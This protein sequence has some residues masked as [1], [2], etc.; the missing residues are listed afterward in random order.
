MIRRRGFRIFVLIFVIVALSIAT[1]SFKEVHISFLGANLDRSGDGP[2]G[3][4]LGLDL[5]GGIDLVYQA[6]LPDEVTVTFQDVVEEQDLRGVLDDLGHSQA[7]IGKK[8]YR[9]Q[10]LTTGDISRK[11]GQEDALRN[12]LEQLTP[13]AAFVTGDETLDVTFRLTPMESDIRIILDDLDY[14]EATILSG[15]QRSF[16]IQGVPL[17]DEVRTEIVQ[18]LRELYPFETFSTE[19]EAINVTFQRLPEPADIRISLDLLGHTEAFIIELDNGVFTL[20]NLS[21]AA[22]AEDEIRQ[23]FEDLSLISSFNTGDDVLEVSFT[24]PVVE[25]DIRTSLDALGYTEATIESS[26]QRSFAI[27]N[28][29]L[30]EPSLQN[31]LRQAISVLSPVSI[32]DLDIIEPTPEQ[33]EGVKKTIQRRVNALGTSEPIIQNLGSDRIWVQLPG[34][35]G[36][37]ISTTFFPSPGPGDLEFVLTQIGRSGDT[38]EPTSL[39]SFAIRP[40]TPFATGDA[41]AIRE[42]I[43]QFLLRPA[44]FETGDNEIS[45][46]FSQVPNIP[47]LSRSLTNLGYGDFTI[48]ETDSNNFV[49]RL[50]DVL[51]TDEQSQLQ[52]DLDEQVHPLISFQATGGIEEAKR[53]IGDTAQLTFKERQCLITI[54]E[55]LANPR[56]CE[57][58]ES[59]GAGRFEDKDIDLTGEDLARAFPARNPTTNQPEVHL[60]FN[61]RGR[62]IFS[63]LTRR[64]VGDQLKRMPIFLDDRQLMAPVVS[65][66]IPDGNTRITGRFTQDEVQTLAIQLESGRLPVPLTPIR[67]GTVD[68]LLGADSLRKSLT[69]GLVGLGLVIVFMLVYYRMAGIVAAVALLVYAV[70][71]MAIFKLVPVTLTLSGIAGLVLSI[72]MAVDANILI[73]ERMKEEMRTGRTLTSSMEVGFRRA[74][75]A[76]R[77]SNVSTIITCL[78]LWWFGDRTGTP[79]VTG[80][81]LTLLIGVVVSMFTAITISRNL[82]QILAFTPLGKRVN[83]FTPEPRRQPVGIAGGGD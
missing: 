9:I 80:L 5:Q 46:T 66:H 10:G 60:E 18:A 72:G 57:P 23:A 53:L 6:D 37:S 73:F 39:E 59:G 21:L 33:M 65:A 44:G 28:L 78:I 76:I 83:L 15:D 49:I 40:A 7:T 63:D 12:R 27:G 14:T 62:G 36:T 79:I 70:I 47:I 26:G 82:L 56:L 25:A 1:L 30:D 41:D 71:V 38:V 20:E 16:T 67:E 22:N 55:L 81:A 11:S 2:I 32:F 45:V 61:G 51:T 42:G 35:G 48:E 54:D 13:I 74:W 77:D 43:E 4:T 50:D 52:K 75:N 68:A 69:A 3:L 29:S 58:I 8:E 24:D 34:A 31:E 64:L 17:T 19:D